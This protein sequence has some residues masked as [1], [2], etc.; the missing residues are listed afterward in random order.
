[1]EL[2]RQDTTA[3]MATRHGDDKAQRRVTTTTP[4]GGDDADL[5]HEG[6]SNDL[7]SW[8]AQAGDGPPWVPHG[9]DPFALFC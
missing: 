8:G 3:A 1:M 9:G 5:R 6:K 4:E 7:P 2:G